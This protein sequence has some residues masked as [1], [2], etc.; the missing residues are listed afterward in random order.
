MLL[1]SVL[2]KGKIFQYKEIVLI[3]QVSISFIMFVCLKYK[4]LTLLNFII[5]KV[6]HLEHKLLLYIF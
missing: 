1:F 5:K 2:L 6:L 4:T 3:T